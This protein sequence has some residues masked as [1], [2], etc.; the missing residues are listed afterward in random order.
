MGRI[1]D[2]G[3]TL[4]QMRMLRAGRNRYHGAYYYAEEIKRNI[5]AR[6][7]TDR[8]WVLVNQQGMCMDHSIVFIHNNMHPQNYEWLSAFDDLVLVCG[9][10]ETTKK[11]KHLGKPI[12]LPLS[13]D[14]ME[15]ME[16]KR[17][18]TKERA[19]F[20]RLSK[21]KGM[22]FAPGTDIVEG[23]KRSEF[24]ARMAEYKEVYA[25]GRTAIEA[26]I[27][28]CKVL[29]YDPRYPNS[30]RWKVLDNKEAAKMLQEK[31]DK[32]DGA[33]R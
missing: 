33:W 4:Y 28:G 27:L 9:V 11:V 31:L 12:F 17:P 22:E 23:L 20:G 1:L 2:H 18:K 6:V 26:K 25:V 29:P 7:K 16:Y 24:L 14:V 10:Y 19:F 30:G 3:N 13:V 8:N 15:V 32:L 21:S 5:I